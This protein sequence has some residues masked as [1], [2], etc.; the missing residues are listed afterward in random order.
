VQE[1]VSPELALP[2]LVEVSFSV[3]A[4]CRGSCRFCYAK[5]RAE[6]EDPTLPQL[7]RHFLRLRQGG[8]RTLRVTGGEPLLRRE[9]L[10]LLDLARHHGF[11]CV[12]NTSGFGGRS[13]AWCEEVFRRCDLL[14]ISLHALDQ[15]AANW[16]GWTG[17]EIGENLAFLRHALEVVP[18]KVV[19]TTLVTTVFQAQYQRFLLLLRYLGAPRWYLNRPMVDP[20]LGTT[21]HPEARAL[22]ALVSDLVRFR[23]SWPGELR[24]SNYP[25]CRF[26]EPARGLLGKNLLLNGVNRLTRDLDGRYRPVGTL[27]LD[28][29]EE[30]GAAWASNPF[31][32]DARPCRL[33][34][35]CRTCQLFPACVGGSRHQAFA[36]HGSYN[37]PD[38]LMVGPISGNGQLGGLA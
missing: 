23:S 3:T 6:V 9:L 1:E 2:G 20:V 10:D 14:I 28:L 37:A 24:L 17:G 19:V 22:D 36:Q 16:L 32:L 38:P 27:A 26:G 35:V 11:S 30:I 12:L 18:A 21:L 29:G 15:A 8:V 5:G 33:P 7:E 34:E 31:R 4:A 13:P 25:H